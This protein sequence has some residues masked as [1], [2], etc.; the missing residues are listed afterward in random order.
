[1]TH[2]T[3]KRHQPFVYG[4]NTFGTHGN[5]GSNG[6]KGISY[7]KGSWG[8]PKDAKADFKGPSKS[9]TFDKNLKRERSKSGR[10]HDSWNKAKKRMSTDDIN[11]RRNTSACMN[12]GEMGH[13]FNDCPK[14]KP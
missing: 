14:P 9:T 6:S 11:A 13:V 5:F 3:S 2:P 8:H 10:N 1:M 4:Q 12:Y 7:T